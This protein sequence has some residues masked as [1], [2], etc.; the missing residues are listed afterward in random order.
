MTLFLKKLSFL[1]LTLILFPFAIQAQ[2]PPAPTA[3][4]EAMKRMQLMVGEW[5]GGGW[6]EF[7]PGK[8]LEFTGHESIQPKTNGTTLLVQGLHKSKSDGKTPERVIH[9]AL[10]I[11]S[12]NEK[13]KA[14]RMK[15][16]LASGAQTDAV[17]S[18]TETGAMQ[19]GL[20]DNRG[21][22]IRYT[23]TIAEKATWNEVGEYS[24]DGKTWRKFFEMNLKHKG[25][26]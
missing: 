10:A 6:I 2:Q 17:I 3:Q 8:K 7:G 5:E 23:I 13:E 18:I 11:I 12:F 9:D 1:A 19:W 24:M 26:N 22:Q 14:Y 21:G 16:C 15:A 25:T 20:P 4:I